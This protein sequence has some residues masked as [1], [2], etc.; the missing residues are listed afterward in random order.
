[1]KIIWHSN[2]NTL[3]MPSQQRALIQDKDQTHIGAK[4]FSNKLFSDEELK[5][6]LI[7]TI[8]CK[9]EVTNFNTKYYSESSMSFIIYDK[10][11]H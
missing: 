4:M 11:N 9:G 3:V 5:I 10:C 8:L 2:Y 7:D 1:M 6:F